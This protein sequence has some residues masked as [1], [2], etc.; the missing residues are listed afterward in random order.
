MKNIYRLI[1]LAVVIIY[2]FN[3]KCAAQ[4]S[5]QYIEHLYATSNT[6][7]SVMVFDSSHS[8]VSYYLEY[9]LAGFTPGTNASPGTGG[10]IWTYT[11]NAHTG[12]S[13]G[14][15]PSTTYDFYLRKQCG[16]VWSAN[17][18]KKSVYS[19]FD[20]SSPTAVTCDSWNPYNAVPSGAGAWNLDCAAEGR[21]RFYSFTPSVTG[22]FTLTLNA[23]GTP[24]TWYFKPVSY[25]CTPYLWDCIGSSNPSTNST[26]NFMLTGGTAYFILQKANTINGAGFSNVKLDCGCSSY[27]NI[28]VTSISPSHAHVDYQPLWYSHIVEYGPYGFTPGTGAAPGVNGAITHSDDLYLQSSTWYDLFIRGDCYSY[29]TYGTNSLRYSFSTPP[30]PQQ[31]Y[32]ALGSTLQMYPSGYAGDQIFP[33]GEWNNGNY[34]IHGEE[35]IAK[36]TPPANGTYE[37]YISTTWDAGGIL[38]RE[39]SDTCDLKYYNVP[40]NLQFVYNTTNE[41]TF[42]MK[43][44]NSNKSYNLLA[45]P[46]IANINFNFDVTINCANAKN[47]LLGATTANSAV[48]SFDCPCPNPVYLEYGPVGF[49]PG[50]GGIGN[51]T[52]IVNV[53]SPY[54][55]TGLS[56]YTQYDVYL[57]SSC[58]TIFTDNVKAFTFRTGIDCA[59]APVLT[60]GSTLTYTHWLSDDS[61][62]WTTSCG[63]YYANNST[64]TVYRFTPTQTGMHRLTNYSGSYYTGNAISTYYK[65]FGTC[66]SSGWNC[67][68]ALN[69]FP[70]SLAFGPLTAGTS[71]LIYFDGASNVGTTIKNI[72]LDCVQSCNATFTPSTD[73]SLCQGKSATLQANTG[74]GITYQWYKNGSAISGAT[75][76]SYVFNAI[77]IYSGAWFSVAENTSCGTIYSNTIYI[78]VS[79]SVLS[80][81]YAVTPLSICTGGQAT[82]IARP[83]FY[84]TTYQWQV[85]GVDIAGATQQTYN[86]PDSGTY[87]VQTSAIGCTTSYSYAIRVNK[88]TSLPAHSIIPSSYI[89]CSGG[90]VLLKLKNNDSFYPD[91]LSTPGYAYQWKLNGTDISGATNT[92]YSATAAGYYTCVITASCGSFTTSS[93]GLLANVTPTISITANGPSTFCNS[94][95]LISATITG[96]IN[97]FTWKKNGVALNVNGNLIATE[98]GAYTCEIS[99]TCLQTTLTSNTINVVANKTPALSPVTGESGFC[100]SSSG[101]IYS[102]S[103]LSGI[104]YNWTLP[105]GASI[106]S[107][108][109]TNN[110]TVSYSSNA[111]AGN[112]CVAGTN[113]CGTGMASCQSTILRTSVI[114]PGTITGATNVCRQSR[115]YS[116]KKIINADYY[117]WAPPPGASVNGSYTTLQ[118]TDTMVVVKFDNAFSGDTLR[119]QSVNCKGMSAQRKLR[120]NSNGPAAPAPIWGDVYGNCNKYGYYSISPVT[121]AIS[122]TW[123]TTVPGATIN[124]STAPYT[125]YYPSTAILYTT[126]ITGKVYV[127]SNWACGSSAERSITVYAKFN[128]PYVING[129]S[130]VCD[131]AQ[132]V[133]YSTYTGA[134]IT[135]FNWIAPSGAVIASGQGTNSVYIN[136]GTTP[137]TADVKVRWS[138]ACAASSYFSKSVTIN[139]CPR[140]MNDARVEL[141]LHPNPF[142]TATTL[143]I[144]EETD[145][146]ASVILIYNIIGKQVQIISKPE[147]HEIEIE[148]KDLPS[149]IYFIKLVTKGVESRV[150]KM[151]VE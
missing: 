12:T 105:T 142:S 51:G 25:G 96:T 71:Y 33:P 18:P 98:T 58:G 84:P 24:S 81:L 34:P 4:C 1:G 114:Q 27:S 50:T 117:L 127:K 85:N 44:L 139:N 22:K 79:A 55:I 104:T 2:G 95:V 65:P 70:Q 110:I 10:T 9:G 115:I 83:S 91:Y 74:A 130:S 48:I 137:S 120:I 128:A 143:T 93:V 87:R 101:N 42:D 102:V 89:I 122:Y 131:S 121:D 134:G 56:P 6:N 146:S 23:T 49:I 151:I 106:T 86:A 125:T 129:P 141:Q 11:T 72:R 66:D 8:T 78:S 41:L 136:F 30:C 144:P 63:S 62:N 43:N 36:F 39:S 124:G 35:S 111:A 77:N 37:G 54:T 88:T 132:N 112:I 47:F 94:N 68:G 126:G 149:G 82:L 26:F 40:D 69:Q 67:I 20:C 148:R 16:T 32:S 7:I 38:F 13:I 103:P 109:G 53:T 107:G 76:S 3:K 133:Q 138:N 97:S 14:V 90:N 29:G 57:R 60:C 119:V 145:L 5:G 99:N 17:T 150:I 123:R 21:E 61:G 118:T 28:A 140:L 147:Q 19:F 92:A 52:M 31:D 46:D 64:E 15:T 100:R 73:F 75:S 135:G 108:Q 59:N 45:F 113:V 116:I 80:N